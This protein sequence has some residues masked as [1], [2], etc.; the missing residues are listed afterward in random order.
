MST[1]RSSRSRKGRKHAFRRVSRRLAGL[2]PKIIKPVFKKKRV[3]LWRVDEYRKQACMVFQGGKR[4][5]LVTSF[6][7]LDLD[8]GINLPAQEGKSHNVPYTY[9]RLAPQ[10]HQHVVQEGIALCY[11]AASQW[12]IMGPRGTMG[13]L[14]R[15]AVFL[16]V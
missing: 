10:P 8:L 14:P 5:R 7:I 11:R 13:P 4:I 9:T 2:P 3:V 6:S 1:L 12:E 15:L 16:S